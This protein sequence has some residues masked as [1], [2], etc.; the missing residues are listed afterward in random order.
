MASLRQ[1]RSASS[2]GIAPVLQ[3]RKPSHDSFQP[4]EQEIAGSM[5]TWSNS[6]GIGFGQNKAP[7]ASA[8]EDPFVDPKPAQGET[9]VVPAQ[10]VVAL[11]P[12]EMIH[13]P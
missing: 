12:T 2:Y 7:A 4:R 6:S 1:P 5:Y 9:V 3:S 13:V 8:P 10:A 11:L